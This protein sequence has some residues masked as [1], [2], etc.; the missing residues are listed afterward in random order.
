MSVPMSLL[1]MLDD[2]PMYGL[3]MKY[4]F[5]ER[6]GGVWPLNVG[7]VYTTIGRLERDGLVGLDREEAGNKVYAITVAGRGR[8]AQ[9][10]GELS[11]RETPS[12]DELVIKLLL[13]IAKTSIDVSA[14]VQAERR[15]LLEQLQEYTRLKADTPEHGDLEWLILLDSLIFKA[16]AQVRWLDACE[17]RIARHDGDLPARVPATTRA[18]PTDEPVTP[19]NLVLP[20]NP[21]TPQDQGEVR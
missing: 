11:R 21:V 15:S 13:A 2:R 1:A 9:W 16:E 7:Q 8:L 10:F 14:V 20:Q 17:A 19:Q 12:R 6:T 4:E 3:E 5:E 18:L